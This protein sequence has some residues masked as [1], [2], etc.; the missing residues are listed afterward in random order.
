MYHYLLPK[1]STSRHMSFVPVGVDP[2]T[3]LQVEQNCGPVVAYQCRS[4]GCGLFMGGTTRAIAEHLKRH[5][6]TSS[7]DSNIPC[8]WEGCTK[9]LK[10][11]S[12]PRHIL[13]HIGVKVCCSVCGVVMCRHDVL[14]KHIRAS[15]TC[16]L[17]SVETHDGPQ[18]IL[19]FPGAISQFVIDQV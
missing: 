14:R 1:N 19:V 10:K 18:G 9:I 4:Q 16:H 12:M 2:Y 15:Q 8:V 13:A 3:Y 5:G 7:G 17:A 6:I 11:G